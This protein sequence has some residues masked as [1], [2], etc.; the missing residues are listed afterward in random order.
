MLL[1]AAGE[2]WIPIHGFM[3]LSRAVEV[4]AATGKGMAKDQGSLE[5][6]KLKKHCTALEKELRRYRDDP[7]AVAR[8]LD[9]KPF[10]LEDVAGVADDL[11]VVFDAVDRIFLPTPVAS[12]IA[13]FVEATHPSAASA[14]PE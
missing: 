12:Y 9:G 3:P 13:R 7:N 14:P 8:D 11:G 10:A 5:L 1:G 4:G 2:V 6:G